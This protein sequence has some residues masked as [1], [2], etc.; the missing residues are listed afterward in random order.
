MGGTG[1]HSH[2]GCVKT[3]AF[4]DGDEGSFDGD[5]PERML[6]TG[7]AMTT[8][9]VYEF[10]IDVYP[11]E[12]T[13][14]ATVDDGTDSVTK[15]DMGYRTHGSAGTYLSFLTKKSKA[16]PADEFDDVRKF[17]VDGIRIGIIPEPSTLLLMAMGS[18]LLLGFRRRRQ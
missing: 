6:S 18:G 7:I 9:G 8:G 15:T 5:D 2:E 1:S 17:S 10:T 13:W 14:D 3:W 11:V 12:K 4:Y 16:T